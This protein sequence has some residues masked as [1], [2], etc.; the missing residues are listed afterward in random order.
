[1]TRKPVLNPEQEDRIQRE[2]KSAGVDPEVYWS[3]IIN[4]LAEARMAETRRALFELSERNAIGERQREIEASL[5]RLAEQAK[6]KPVP[7]RGTVEERLSAYRAW[8]SDH[9]PSTPVP[10]PTAYDRETLYED[11]V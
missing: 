3:T 6:P 2:A 11:R 4:G 5:Q 9:D 7:P 10:P 8:V 1:M